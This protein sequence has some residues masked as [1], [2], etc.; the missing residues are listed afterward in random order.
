MVAHLT[1]TPMKIFS[2]KNVKRSLNKK[3]NV[4]LPVSATEDMVV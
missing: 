4:E 1:A 2:A 3:A